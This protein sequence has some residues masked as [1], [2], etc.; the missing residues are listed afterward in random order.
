MSGADVARRNLLAMMLCFAYVKQIDQK[1]PAVILQVRCM[2]FVYMLT[3]TIVTI[4]QLRA[5]EKAKDAR[6][7][8]VPA[9]RM[10]FGPEAGREIAAEVTQTVYAYDMEELKKRVRSWG[11]NAFLLTFIHLRMKTVAPLVLTSVTG[12]LNAWSDKLTMIHLRG[13]A[14]EGA[15]QRP[16]K[17]DMGPLASMFSAFGRTGDS[18]ANQRTSSAA[19]TETNNREAEARS[20]DVAAE[21]ATVEEIRDDENENEKASTLRR[22]K[23]GAENA[24]DDTAEKESVKET[25]EANDASSKKTD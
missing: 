4:L 19:Q 9:Q 12:L 3:M 25:D 8:R 13:C 6:P 7:V 15:L 10:P 23:G 16:W 5:I 18:N 22:R 14:D 21:P 20:A 2:F 24:T 11:L 1:D 17:P